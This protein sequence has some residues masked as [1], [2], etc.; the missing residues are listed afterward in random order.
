MNPN[1][2]AAN[3]PLIAK[4]IKEY[5]FSMVHLLFPESCLI[6][7]SELTVHEKHVCSFCQADLHFTHFEKYNEPNATEQLFSGRIDIQG[8]FSLLYF[9]KNKSTQALL[10]QLKYKNNSA[11]GNWLGKEIGMRL[12]QHPVLSTVDLLIPTPIHPR[13]KF[14]RGY[15]QSELLA[16]GIAEHLEIAVNCTALRKTNFTGSQ[17]KLN[18]F[19][20]WTNVSAG[21]KVTTSI[22]EAKHVAVVDDVITTGSTL[23]S[24]LQQLHKHRPDLKLSVISLALAK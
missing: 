19:D 11:L 17:T 7:E 21:F 1:K 20:R 9:E 5:F 22:F 8:G 10:H 13:K 4:K 14:I 3:T 16:N 23:E 15:N 6:C 2:N 18:R 24:I 12:Q